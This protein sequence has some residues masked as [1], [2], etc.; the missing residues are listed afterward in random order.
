[1]SG[2]PVEPPA[3]GRDAG[4]VVVTTVSVTLY[5]RGPEPEWHRDRRLFGPWLR[6]E[7]ELAGF[8]AVRGIEASPWEAVNILVANHRAV[9]ERRW[10]G[11][12][13][14]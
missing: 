3:A 14:Q 2:R 8:A 11:D 5:D 12:A 4:R 7:A 9:L 6:Y 1:V 13:C 10:S